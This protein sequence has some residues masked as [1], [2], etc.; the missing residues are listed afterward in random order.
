MTQLRVTL[1]D[2]GWG[3]SILLEATDDNGDEHFGLIDSNDT[4][5][6]RSSL[7]FLKRH[8]EKKK[9]DLKRKPIFEFVM[10]SHEHADHAQGLKAIMREFGTQE[11]WYPKSFSLS[12]FTS[13]IR[14]AN[15][16]RY[17]AHHEAL[18][19]TK[20]LPSFGGVAMGVLWPH[21]N[22]IHASPNDNSIVLKLTLGSHSVLLTGDAEESVWSSI[23]PQIPK[24]T[25]CFKVPHHGSVNGT[26]DSAG[27][28]PWLDKCPATSRLLISAHIKPHQHPDQLVIDEFNNRS[29]DVLR[30]DR[31]YHIVFETDGLTHSFSYS[32]V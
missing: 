11:F 8:F 27:G 32:H 24:N 13:L 6:L 12:S 22:K 23:A 15:N 25:V 9:I 10:L 29:Y 3:D 30:T 16:R 28:T 31:H 14:F 17:V 5:Y 7:I 2:V 20:I 19:S 21:Y 18:N 1:I 26:F 4:T